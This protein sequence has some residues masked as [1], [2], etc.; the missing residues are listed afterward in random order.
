MRRYNVPPPYI[1]TIRKPHAHRASD[2][3]GCGFTRAATSRRATRTARPASRRC[4]RTSQVHT[5]PPRASTPAASEQR[6]ATIRK[7]VKVAVAVQVHRCDPARDRAA[8]GQCDARR[9]GAVARVDQHSAG[10]A[11]AATRHNLG[12]QHGASSRATLP[13][14]LASWRPRSK[15]YRMSENAQHVQKGNHRRVRASAREAF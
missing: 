4:S 5:P 8:A 10:T 7:H 14:W 15:A 13:A 6:T 11:I 9:E 1:Q 2:C 12:H 3:S